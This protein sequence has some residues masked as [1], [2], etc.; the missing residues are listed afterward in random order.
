MSYR[1]I[2]NSTNMSII[3]A[4]D[5]FECCEVFVLSIRAVYT[6]VMVV[7]FANNSCGNMSSKR[8]GRS[9]L[10]LM[11]FCLG[12]YTLQIFKALEDRQRQ[13]DRHTD[14]QDSL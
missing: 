11:G 13:S 14:T 4:F 10:N 2:V 7:P 8:S 6:L 12:P 5:V 1:E 9:R 3:D